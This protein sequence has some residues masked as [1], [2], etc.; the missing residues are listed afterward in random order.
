M[1]KRKILI[2]ENSI[3]ITGALNSVVRTSTAL[4][5][6]Y[7]FVF[8]LPVGSKASSLVKEKGF[9]FFEIPMTELSK[10]MESVLFYVPN[11]IRSVYQVKRIIKNEQID[12]VHVNDFYNLIM[13]LW[14]LFGSPV[15]YV[16]HV[17]FVPNRFPFLLRKLWITSHLLFSEKIIAVSRFVVKQLPT[18]HKV[19]CIYNSLPEQFNSRIENSDRRKVLLYVGNFMEGKGQD[20]AIRSFALISKTYADWKLRLVGGDMGMN[21]NKMYQSSLINLVKDLSIEKQV[22]WSGFLNDPCIEYQ[23]ASIA[24]NFSKSESFS[25]TVQEAMFYRCPVVATR[26]GGPEELIEHNYSGLLVPVDDVTA[27]SEAMGYLIKN[28]NERSRIMACAS[29]SVTEKCSKKNTIDRLDCVYQNI[30]DPKAKSS[31]S[32]S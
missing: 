27:M 30:L 25:L 6:Q 17:N 4:G 11:L 12:L 24:L 23:D 1:N 29:E 5:N 28:P 14:R 13:P 8:V 20:L 3:D 21:K 32:A 9:R 2:I 19:V 22:E 18:S 15:K 16:C 7:D 26:S 10:R 31:K